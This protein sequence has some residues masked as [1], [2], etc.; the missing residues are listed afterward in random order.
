MAHQYLASGLTVRSDM[1]LPGL[2]AVDVI[3]EPDLVVQA[4][5]VPDRLPDVAA[6]GSTWW[7]ARDRLLLD[8]PAVIRLLL[9]GGSLVEYRLADGVT[10]AD[11]AVFVTGTALGL[12]LHQRGRMVLHASAVQVGEG[13]VLFCGPSGAGKSTLAA[14]LATAGYALVCD[15]LCAIDW[16]NATVPSVHRDGRRMKLWENAVDRLGVAERRGEPIR[17]AL[18]KFFV[19][20]PQVAAPLLPVIGLYVLREVRPPHRAGVEEANLVDAALL[21]R[22]AAYRQ[23]LVTELGQADRYFA[24]AAAMMRRAR[25]FNL[26]RPLDFAE[27]P[28]TVDGLARQWRALGWLEASG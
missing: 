26:T 7:L 1:P 22:A 10:A 14:A 12:A 28:A 23:R 3:G 20:P 9:T 21:I 11:A 18:R 5:D 16:E 19:D 2:T 8:I 6:Q 25:V 24:A 4:A 17:P 15:D 27:L 13:A